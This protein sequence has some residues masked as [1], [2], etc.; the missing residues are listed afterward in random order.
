M[1]LGEIKSS[2]EHRVKGVEQGI[3]NNSSS[4]KQ[5]RSR[6]SQGFAQKLLGIFSVRKNFSTF[7]FTGTDWL[8]VSALATVSESP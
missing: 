3:K 6:F 7:L 8:L 5:R 2:K 4:N 1:G